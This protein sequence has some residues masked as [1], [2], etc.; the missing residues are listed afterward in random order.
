MPRAPALPPD[1]DVLDLAG[2]ADLLTLAAVLASVTIYVTGDTGP[3]H[4]AAAMG[5]PVVAV[6]GLSDPA[7]YAPLAPQRRIVRIDLPVQPVQPDPA[8]AGRCRGTCPTA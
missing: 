5:T 8:A 2:T 3:M 4:L 7:R 1:V 6:F